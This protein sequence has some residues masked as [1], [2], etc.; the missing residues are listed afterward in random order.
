MEIVR[1]RLS[2]DEITPANT[3]YNP[4][5][6]TVQSTPDGGTTW[7]DNPGIDPRSNSAGLLP[8]LTT[9]D[10]ACDAA[11]GMVQLIK[12]LIAGWNAQNNILGATSLTIEFVLLFLPGFGLLADLALIALQAVF[13]IGLSSVNAAMT[14]TVYDQLLCIFRDR[15]DDSGQLDATAFAGLYDDVEAQLDA[16]AADVCERI[17]DILGFV[18]LSNAGVHYGL[19]GDCGVCGWCMTV[20]LTDNDGGFVMG[21]Q[22]G[23]PYGTYSAGVGW[24]A[25]DVNSSDRTIIEGTLDL[26]GTFS[27]TKLELLYDTEPSGCSNCASSGLGQY[28]GSLANPYQFGNANGSC[29][30]ASE[31]DAT[32]TFTASH[33]VEAIAFEAQVAFLCHGGSAT[34]KR[35]T[36]YGT[37]DMPTLTGWVTC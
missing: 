9:G 26:G 28:M 8:A 23:L 2:A 21:V 30:I 31:T 22:G 10:P 27:L 7:N 3:R 37:G 20:D 25:S 29:D 15:L 33:N 17:F 1:K 36:M 32:N 24:I 5:T 11:A 18:G 6:D 13:F 14:D 12:D 16:T 4:G 35:V 19:T 34:F